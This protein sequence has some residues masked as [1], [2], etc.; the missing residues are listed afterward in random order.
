MNKGP[1]WMAVQSREELLNV[2]W[3]YEYQ[4]YSRTVDTHVR[5]LREK[6]GPASDL[7][8]TVRG[9]RP[10]IAEK[11]QFVKK[12]AVWLAA[13]GL[14]ASIFLTLGGAGGW[15][16]RGQHETEK[17]NA[18]M[19]Q[20]FM[21]TAADAYGL[22]AS[23]IDPRTDDRTQ[24]IKSFVAQLYESFGDDFTPP[25]LEAAGFDF[26]GGRLVPS[27]RGPAAQLN[28][29]DKDDRR[30]ALFLV[31]G[32]TSGPIARMSDFAPQ[33]FGTLEAIFVQNETRSIYFW[34]RKP[35]KY[36][37]VSEMKRKDLSILVN[38]IVAQLTDE[39]SGKAR[40]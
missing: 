29:A 10:Q 18:L 40:N 19:I 36:A 24:R 17:L 4:G 34:E 16:L 28:Y 1:A 37:L 14:A 2:V 26:A 11:R 8:Q 38:D 31:R 23:D 25:G 13:S 20:Q 9:G 35:L 22:Y 12:R 33:K 6:L 32:V 7:V 21:S 39:S 27:A 5:R 3:G 30:V 15:I